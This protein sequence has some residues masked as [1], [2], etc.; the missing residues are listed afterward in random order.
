MFENVFFGKVVLLGVKEFHGLHTDLKMIRKHLPL[1]A[2]L[3]RISAK[4][5][6]RESIDKK[7]EIKS[8]QKS[9]EERPPSPIY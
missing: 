1:T 6:K 5:R 3:Y 7:S 8:G 2:I 9:S 4:L